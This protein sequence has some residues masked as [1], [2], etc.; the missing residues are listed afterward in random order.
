MMEILLQVTVVQ[1]HAKLKVPLAVRMFLC[2]L[3]ASVFV[4][5]V[6]GL[7]VKPVMMELLMTILVVSQIVQ[8]LYQVGIALE[9]LQ[10][11]K[12]P[13]SNFVMME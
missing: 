5:M 4:G 2:H 10:Q 7:L 6:R 1:A 3:F 13:V 9:E 11:H 12:I 8:V